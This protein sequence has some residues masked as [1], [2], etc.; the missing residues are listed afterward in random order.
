MSQH[1]LILALLFAAKNAA[2]ARRLFSC[3]DISG[4][5]SHSE[6]DLALVVMLRF[7]TRDIGQLDRIFRRS[8]LMREKWLELHGSQPY[9]HLT[10]AKALGK[11]GHVYSGPRQEARATARQADAFGIVPA[12]VNDRLNGKG[13]LTLRVYIALALYANEKREAW[14][15]IDQLAAD[16]TASARWVKTA[17]R[18]LKEARVAF[19]AQRP[20]TS[21]LYTLPRT[22]TESDTLFAYDGRP[23]QHPSHGKKGERFRPIR[24]TARRERNK[25]SINTG[26][27]HLAHARALSS[28]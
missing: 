9:G 20:R 19:V 4:Y 13:E 15:S 25:T 28:I 8:A 2:K 24:V 27:T 22:M 12:W 5:P 16:C 17:I 3:G 18:K 14:P 11:G 6:A 23:M 21:N 1:L 26:E 7:F 10:I